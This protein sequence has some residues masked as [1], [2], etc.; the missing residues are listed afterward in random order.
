MWYATVVC[1]L[2]Q[3]CM[4]PGGK[5]ASIMPKATVVQCVDDAELALKIAGVDLQKIAIDCD[6]I[7]IPDRSRASPSS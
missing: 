4:F 2:A 7:P 6:F 5:Y 1:I 3:S